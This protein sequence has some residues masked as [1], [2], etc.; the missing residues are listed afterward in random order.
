MWRL[1]NK[2]V[3][4]DF[5]HASVLIFGFRTS[6]QQWLW[7][8][9]CSNLWFPDKQAT[10]ITFWHL[11]SHLVSGEGFWMSNIA[12]VTVTAHHSLLFLCILNFQYPWNLKK[13]VIWSNSN[14]Q[15]M[16]M[17]LLL[18]FCFRDQT[19]FVK[20]KTRKQCKITI[21]MSSDNVFTIIVWYFIKNAR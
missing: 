6:R 3:D 13:K 5:S 19:I 9:I 11:I 8:C 10:L 12:Y 21:N 20:K 2:A 4:S 17:Y 16:F 15:R 18:L 1:S 7:P 14:F